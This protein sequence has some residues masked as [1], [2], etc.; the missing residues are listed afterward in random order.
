VV[1]EPAVVPRWLCT[2]A[3]AL[4]WDR[5]CSPERELA[6]NDDES[7]AWAGSDHVVV[8]MPHEIDINNSA[9]IGYQLNLALLRGVGMVIADFTATTFSD[10]SGIRELALARRRASDMNVELRAVFVS[11]PVL[12]TFALA[13]LDQVLPVYASLETALVGTPVSDDIQA[14]SKPVLGNGEPGLYKTGRGIRG[15]RQRIRTPRDADSS[16]S[17]R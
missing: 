1:V 12:R 7:P 15:K 5:G 2:S 4:R 11:P 8:A 9:E 16:G 13:G 17:C 6:M 10:S 3:P 14:S